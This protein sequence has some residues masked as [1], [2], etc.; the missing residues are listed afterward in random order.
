MISR[1]GTNE[2]AYDWINLI[3]AEYEEIPGLALTKP[4]ARRLWGL[5]ESLCDWLLDE[6]VT[7]H[8]LRKTG[9]DRYVRADLSV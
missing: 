7:L 4:Q 9:E 1:A 3:R 8:F 6:M 5:D 2:T